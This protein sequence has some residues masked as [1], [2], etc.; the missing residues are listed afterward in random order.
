[1]ED[2]IFFAIMMVPEGGGGLHL[3]T[4]FAVCLPFAWTAFASSESLSS[5]HHSSFLDLV[6]SKQLLKIRVP[7]IRNDRFLNKTFSNIFVYC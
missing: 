2:P 1:M 6:S 3:F 4:A 7:S 5:F